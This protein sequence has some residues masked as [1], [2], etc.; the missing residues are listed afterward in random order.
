MLIGG[1]T[2]SA[3]FSSYTHYFNHQS[4]TWKDG[5]ILKKGRNSHTS[6]I[7]TDH[8]TFAQHIAV[9]GGQPDQAMDTIE[10]LY[11]GET[12]WKNGISILKN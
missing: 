9:V 10:L 1:R 5:P 2:N 4:K 11:S 7:V 8:I 12:Q 3:Y 6:G